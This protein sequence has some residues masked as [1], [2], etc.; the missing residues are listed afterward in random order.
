MA[1]AASDATRSLPLPLPPGARVCAGARQPCGEDGRVCGSGPGE[2]LLR[3]CTRICM[4][5]GARLCACGPALGC[6][7]TAAKRLCMVGPFCNFVV[8]RAMFN[9]RTCTTPAYIWLQVRPTG[10]SWLLDR[11]QEPACIWLQPRPLA[12]PACFTGCT[13][14]AHAVRAD[15]GGQPR[16]PAAL[17]APEGKALWS[18]RAWS[19][20][21]CGQSPP[22]QAHQPAGPVQL[23][24]HGQHSW[25]MASDVYLASRSRAMR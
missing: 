12:C 19:G 3:F 24:R 21:V 8:S 9:R 23:Q 13:R 16:A 15:E 6:S 1:P 2:L 22:Q 10:L 14:G 17:A 18:G 5:Q 11:E 20:G 25:F 4:C 7:F